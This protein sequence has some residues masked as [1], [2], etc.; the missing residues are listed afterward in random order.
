MKIQGLALIGYAMHAKVLLKALF[1]EH[2]L[3]PGWKSKIFDWVTTTLVHCFLLG[4]VAFGD[5]IV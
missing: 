5:P 4:D 2:G 1:W 3:S